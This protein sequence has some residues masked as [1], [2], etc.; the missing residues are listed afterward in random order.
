M[1]NLMGVNLYNHDYRTINID[2]TVQNNVQN[3]VS[4]F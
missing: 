1:K 4:V 3:F 2:I